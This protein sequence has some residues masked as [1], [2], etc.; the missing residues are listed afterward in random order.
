MINTIV[1][2]R[3]YDS[4][5]IN[6]TKMA[7]IKNHSLDGNWRNPIGEIHSGLSQGFLH[8]DK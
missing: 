1:A 6:Q 4:F 7:M 2:S 8:I 3:H 5:Y